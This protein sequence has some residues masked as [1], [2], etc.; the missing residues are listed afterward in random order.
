MVVA[1]V[2]DHSLGIFHRVK[3]RIL[4]RMTFFVFVVLLLHIRIAD[5]VLH[6]DRIVVVPH[7]ISF[8]AVV[9]RDLHGLMIDHSVPFPYCNM[10]ST[11]EWPL[12]E[13]NN[14]PVYTPFRR[15]QC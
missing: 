10:F 7:C 3:M 9:V 6:I 8:S 12:K 5:L 15:N 13:R 2:R 1:I 11:V 4:H 14:L